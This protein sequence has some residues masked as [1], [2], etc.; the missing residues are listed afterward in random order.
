MKVFL[1]FTLIIIVSIPS[2]LLSQTEN[3]IDNINRNFL[4]E[5][6]S[7]LFPNEDIKYPLKLDIVND[8]ESRTLA[9]KTI[10]DNG[11]LLTESLLQTWD[12]SNW[13]DSVKYTLTYDGNNNMSEELKQSWDGSNWKIRTK[14]TYTYDGNNNLIEMLYQYKMGSNWYTTDKR[15]FK[16][17]GNNNLIE[18]LRQDGGVDVFPWQDDE[19]DIFTYDGN[20]NRIE[21]LFQDW[22][23]TD[24]NWV[25]ENKTKF[26]YDGNNNMVEKLYQEWDG[27]N[28]VNKLKH[29]Y[30]YILITGVGRVEDGVTT[31]SLSNNYP[32]PFNPSTLINYQI[33]D[34]GYV[35]LKVFDVLGNEVATLVNENKGKGQYNITFDA[36]AL[37]SGVYIYQLKVNDYLS[38]KKML[39]MK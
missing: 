12:G 26:R 15:K 2:H 31:Y 37:S 20:N 5:N 19:R 10:L 11:F 3:R 39:L 22:D 25:N 28:W 17:D 8:K 29:I 34:A 32:N 14:I 21:W 30:S 36:S 38:T 23:H 35:I 1:L 24:S 33:P 6:I 18:K 16:Y 13:V 7:K 4:S 27:S 9:N